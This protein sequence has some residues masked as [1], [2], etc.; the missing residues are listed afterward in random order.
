M[1]VDMAPFT[2]VRVRQ[3]FR[4]M[5][6]REKMNRLVFGGHGTHGNVVFSIWD[7]DYDHSL[8]QRQQDIAQAKSLLKQAGHENLTI[9]LVTADIAQ[10]T[11]NMAQLL[12]QD[13][14]QAGVT[15]QQW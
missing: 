7:T 15:V 3:A 2:D 5:V 11:V 4:L 6:D 10:G 14:A 9:Q 13:A 1:R 8:P 12:A